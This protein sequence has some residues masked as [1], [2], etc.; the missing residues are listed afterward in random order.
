MKLYSQRLCAQYASP[1]I[2]NAH[3]RS[4]ECVHGGPVGGRCRSSY[5]VFTDLLRKQYTKQQN[6]GP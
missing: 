3:R 2:G 6:N 1:K 5:K 4:I